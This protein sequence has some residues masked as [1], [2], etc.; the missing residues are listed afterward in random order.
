MIKNIIVPN[1][2]PAELLSSDTG[3]GSYI[4]TVPALQLSE[5]EADD[6]ILSSAGGLYK[7]VT[8]T[9]DNKVYLLYMEG[10]SAL[11]TD[12]TFTNVRSNTPGLTCSDITVPDFDKNTGTIVYLNN[13]SPIT[14]TS[15]EVETVKLFLHF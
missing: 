2:Q 8:T 1:T 6:E 11:T 7:V 14:R 5:Y 3:T 13:L 12:T 4:I 10:D 15:Q 9:T